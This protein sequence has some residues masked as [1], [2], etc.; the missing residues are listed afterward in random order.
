MNKLL[1]YY[2]DMRPNSELTFKQLCSKIAVLFILL[3]ARRR[4]ALLTTDIANVIV[5]TDQAILHPNKTLQ[6]CVSYFSSNFY[7]FTN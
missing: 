1:T 7:F 3:G 5:Q 2:D 6:A 4:Q